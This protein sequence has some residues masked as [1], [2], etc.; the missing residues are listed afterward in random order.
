MRAPS[1]LTLREA[2]EAW[3]VGA[4][5]GTIR[6]R[7]GDRY[8]PSVVRRLRDRAAAASAARARRPKLSE[9]RRADVQD[10][11]DRLL[12]RGEDPSTI[13]NTLMPLRAIFRRAVARGDVAVNPTTGLELPAVRGRRDRIASPEEAARLLDALPERDRAMW[14][15]A[16]Y[17]A[18]AAASCRR[19]AGRTSTSRR[20]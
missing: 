2:A 1:Q 7:S 8:K 14:A 3:L 19:F 13:R 16:L 10:F 17:A 20:A 12:A 6:N 18:F 15:T 11:A 5:E 9:I 4:R